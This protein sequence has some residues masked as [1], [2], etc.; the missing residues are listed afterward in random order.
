MSNTEKVNTKWLTSVVIITSDQNRS[1]WY[2]WYSS[3]AQISQ[4]SKV[5][6]R[7]TE[8]PSRSFWVCLNYWCILPPSG[9]PHKLHL[10]LQNC[11][12]HGKQTFILFLH[13]ATRSSLLNVWFNSHTE[14]VLS[15]EC[16]NNQHRCFEMHRSVIRVTWLPLAAERLKNTGQITETMVKV[17]LGTFHL[18]DAATGVYRLCLH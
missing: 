7:K 18:V 13:G 2:G 14:F 10:W 6:I 12:L 3:I 1:Q 9:W 15:L 8:R 16:E 11:I 5:F 4:F 17:L